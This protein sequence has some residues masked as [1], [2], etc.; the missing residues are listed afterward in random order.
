MKAESY[1]GFSD[2]DLE[3][4]ARA[5]QAAYTIPP[6]WPLAATVAVNPYLGQ[7]EQTLAET[8]ARL[9][10]VAG[11]KVTQPRSVL[12]AKWTEGDITTADLKAAL[13]ASLADGPRDVT[14]LIQTLKET[15]PAPQPIPTVASLAADATGTD[16]PGIIRERI[17][18]WAAGYFDAGQALW[19]SA[20]GKGAFA[21]WQSYAARD[22]TPE[23]AGI[24]SFTAR[25]ASLPLPACR[26]L[27]Q[28]CAQLG[29]SPAA[30]ETYFHQL[31]LELG[32]WAQLARRDLFEADMRD[33]T[34]T[35]VSDLLSLRLVW[36]AALLDAF[37]AQIGHDWQAAREAH[38]TPLAPTRHQIADAILQEAAEH[39]YQR[40]LALQICPQ[41]EGASEAPPRPAL[42][43]A[44]CIDVRSERYRRQ[45]EAQNPSI[46][47]LGFAGFFGMGVSHQDSLS[48]LQE[49][50]LPVLLAPQ[51]QSSAHTPCTH[52]KRLS[53]RAAR[54]WGRFRQAAVSS[55]AFVEASG[56]LYVAKLMRDTLG[57]QSASTAADAPQF[58][59]EMSMTAKAEMAATILRAMSLT[60][61]FAPIVLLLGHG[62]SVANNPH[63]SALQCGA[64]GG[65]AGDVNA[66]LLAG[67][68]NDPEIRLA[69]MAHGIEI[70]MDTRFVAGLHD[71]TTDE[72]SLYTIDLDDPDPETALEQ[73]K[74]W[75]TAASAQTALERTAMLSRATNAA[76]ISRRALD[77]AET[78]P[79]WGL[80]GC[81]AFIAAPR[82]RTQNAAL[83]GRSFLH[84][85]DWRHDPEFAVL[86]L[87]LTAPVVVASWISLSY[88]GAVVSPQLFGSGNKL[89]HNVA[90]GI[91]ALEGN[92]GVLRA[93]LPMQS[94]H[95][96]K[97]FV[98]EALRLSVVVDAPAEA[99]NRILDK[100]P[101]VKALFDNRWLHLFTLDEEGG[102]AQRYAG[103]RDWQDLR[104]ARTQAQSA[105]PALVD[106]AA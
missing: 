25:V 63:A 11:A 85:Y 56:P 76:D 92:G 83:H 48:D 7:T 34:S 36:E 97:S 3:L 98:H 41:A 55:F 74:E 87:I 52:D 75:L 82:G 72:I 12:M 39:A 5:A 2:I 89:L 100:H 60:E 43:A 9:D 94:V 86:E 47:T 35:E 50:R 54:A 90:G 46:Q 61:R 32:G 42:Q 96:G 91:G 38:A 78:R 51:H 8:A 57:L 66:R 45:L 102:L 59:N 26:S 53:A 64:C 106:H 15:A 88:Y 73:V 37:G 4:I 28:S 17:S 40:K 49:H 31:L 24:T 95:D 30:A 10:R 19:S 65:H 79:E 93:G 62:A 14:S 27:A 99:I 16:W 105:Q 84:D 71:T 18:A 80:A 69:L 13:V 68:L 20:P 101:S 6:L 22:L 29:L 67:L 77:W 58:R 103:G 104:A 33:A 44:F 21:S 70:P 23:I 81:S 1:T